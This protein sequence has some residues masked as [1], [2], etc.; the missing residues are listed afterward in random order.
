MTTYFKVTELELIALK[1]V[2]DSMLAMVNGC[3]GF[4]EEAKRGEKAIN[5]ILKRAGK[6]RNK[7]EYSKSSVI[8]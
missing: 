4:D 3:E 7:D 5:S 2:S 8:I 1:D 6:K